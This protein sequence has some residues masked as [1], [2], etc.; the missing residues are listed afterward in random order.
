MPFLSTNLSICVCIDLN[1]SPFFLFC[2]AVFLSLFRSWLALASLDIPYP[3]LDLLSTQ[4]RESRSD[5]LMVLGEY[6]EDCEFVSLNLRVLHLIAD[7]APGTKDVSSEERR[8]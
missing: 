1:I 5:G 3:L 4:E 6:I 7:M 8:T 2:S